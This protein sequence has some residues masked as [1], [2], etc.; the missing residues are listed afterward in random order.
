MTTQLSISMVHLCDHPEL[1]SG[2]D[3][4]FVHEWAPW[5]GPDGDGDAKADLAAFRTR[6]ALPICLVALDARQNVVGTAALKADSV[7]SELGVGPW[8]AAVLVADDHR[9]QGIGTAL[10]GAIEREA[11]RLGFDTIYTS[12]DTA[13]R[14][15]ERRGW[16]PIAETQSLTGPLV[17]YRWDAKTE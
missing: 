4:W 3:A 9:E 5:Y 14:I 16:T 6:D 13:G 10:V 2:L 17:V 11:E 1:L 15:M 12:T 8:L 7:G